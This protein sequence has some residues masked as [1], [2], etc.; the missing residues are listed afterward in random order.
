MNHPRSSAGLHPKN[1]ILGL[2]SFLPL[3][4]ES[5]GFLPEGDVTRELCQCYPMWLTK[6]LS[7]GGFLLDHICIFFAVRFLNLLFKWIALGLTHGPSWRFYF[8]STIFL[9]KHIL[10]SNNVI[11]KEFCVYLFKRLITRV[12]STCN[13]VV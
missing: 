7:H 1:R 3:V 2:P 10:K 9:W 11:I 5:P 12:L 4:L 8:T 6:K 13:E